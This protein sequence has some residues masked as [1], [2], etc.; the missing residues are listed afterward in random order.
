M[1]RFRQRFSDISSSASPL[2]WVAFA[3]AAGFLALAGLMVAGY[4]L[5][6]PGGWKGLGLTVLWLG[7]LVALSALAFYRPDESVPVLAAATLPAVGFGVWALLDYE[8]ARAWEDQNGPVSLVLVLVVAAA[9]VVLGLS[10]PRP[11]GLLLVAVTVVP[12]VLAMIGAGSEWLLALSIGVVSAPILICGVL[13]LI[14][15]RSR[16]GSVEHV[17]APR[18]TSGH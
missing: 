18:V 10:R 17:G 2:T 14:A 6:D 11:A 12:S 9:L 16:A 15:G 7:P 4:G 5:T 13:Y 1:T 8:G 3:I